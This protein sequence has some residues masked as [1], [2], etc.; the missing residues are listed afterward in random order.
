VVVTEHDPLLLA[1]DVVVGVEDVVVQVLEEQENNININNTTSP[2]GNFSSLN[3][4]PFLNFIS[5]NFSV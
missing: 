5:F 3:F 2:R 1:G 4:K